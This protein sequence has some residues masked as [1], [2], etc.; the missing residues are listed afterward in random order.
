MAG[1]RS[2]VLGHPTKQAHHI[3]L[4]L[5]VKGW[6]S[7]GAWGGFPLTRHLTLHAKACGQIVKRRVKENPPYGAVRS[8]APTLSQHVRFVTSGAVARDARSDGPASSPMR[9]WRNW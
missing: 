8:H 5:F 9:S 1:R 6:T 3:G 4:F 7:V 2:E